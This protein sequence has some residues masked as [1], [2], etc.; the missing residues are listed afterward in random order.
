VLD[1][2]E[3]S[4]PL[5]IARLHLA[6]KRPRLAVLELEKTRARGLL[7]PEILEVLTIAYTQTGELNQA[8]EV[9]KSLRAQ[10]PTYRAGQEVQAILDAIR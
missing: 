10:Y 5:D 3:P 1:S 4:I 6:A 7:I 8:A 9:A 2:W